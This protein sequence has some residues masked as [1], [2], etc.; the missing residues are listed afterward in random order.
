MKISINLPRKPPYTQLP[1]TGIPK[2]AISYCTTKTALRNIPERHGNLKSGLTITRLTTKLVMLLPISPKRAIVP[3]RFGIFASA[4]FNSSTMCHFVTQRKS[5]TTT[6]TK[7]HT[8][9]CASA[10]KGQQ[11]NQNNL[12]F[13]FRLSRLS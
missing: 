8:C 5:L 12:S 2:K 1:Q 4:A 3:R 9:T 7:D 10:G 11:N 13:V 6:D